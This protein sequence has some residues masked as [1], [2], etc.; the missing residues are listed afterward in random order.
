MNKRIVSIR[1]LRDVERF[2]ARKHGNEMSGDTSF[3]TDGGHI[4][5]VLPHPD[6]LRWYHYHF[7][8]PLHRSSLSPHLLI[9]FGSLLLLDIQFTPAYAQLGSFNPP[10][11]SLEEIQAQLKQEQHAR[12]RQ[13]EGT[14]YASQRVIN[15]MS[16]LTTERQLKDALRS[17][18]ITLQ[19]HQQFREQ[20]QKYLEEEKARATRRTEEVRGEHEIGFR[21]SLQKQFDGTLAR[22]ETLADLPV[23]ITGEAVRTDFGISR[24]NRE[25]TYHGKGRYY[26][27]PYTE[28]TEVISETGEKAIV[29]VSNT[30]FEEYFGE[31]HW[32]S[33]NRTDH[34]AFPTTY[35]A[36]STNSLT[37]YEIDTVR[38]SGAQPKADLEKGKWYRESWVEDTTSTEEPGILYRR[39]VFMANYDPT[40]DNLLSYFAIAWSPKAEQEL[41][42]IEYQTTYTST[43]DDR[44]KPETEEI[45]R[46]EIPAPSDS[47][48]AIILDYL[49][50]DELV[51]FE[52]VQYAYGISIQEG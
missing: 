42:L 14:R 30:F 35:T 12:A 28:R 7:V 37:P 40:N 41:V 24:S 33:S 15:G 1:S 29:E 52:L 25:I 51:P 21:Y 4:N 44:Q 2:L 38:V 20:A 23:R 9:V 13:L 11:S 16:D 27:L 31:P 8:F 48:L 49:M 34:Y 45:K 22:I 6:A 26:R 5:R 18:A 47:K 10:S 32:W 43:P 46:T 3:P 50:K 17:N 19:D 36:T 39:Q